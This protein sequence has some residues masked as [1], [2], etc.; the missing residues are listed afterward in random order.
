MSGN[1]YSRCD[2]S[3]CVMITTVTA[4]VARMSAVDKDA[5]LSRL[6]FPSIRTHRTTM[7][8]DL[9]VVVSA[10]THLISTKVIAG[11]GH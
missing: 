9:H 1:N 3:R 11:E 2:I 6:L 7:H 10:N 8:I 4:A 5:T